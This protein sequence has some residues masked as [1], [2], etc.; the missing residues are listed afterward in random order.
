MH[1]HT[2]RRS[3]LNPIEL[4]ETDNLRLLWEKYNTTLEIILLYWRNYNQL[5]RTVPIPSFKIDG[6]STTITNKCHNKKN[7]HMLQFS[8]LPLKP[9]FPLVSTGRFFAISFIT[10]WTTYLS[11]NPASLGF[12]SMWYVLD[13]V[14]SSR[15][16][17]LV[18]AWKHNLIQIGVR[19]SNNPP[20]QQNVDQRKIVN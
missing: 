4:T 16:I 11:W 8:G 9:F 14:V 12:N 20:V 18:P 13:N 7:Q 17:V 10:S 19:T 1:Y 5:Q 15:S 6:A 2:T 3:V